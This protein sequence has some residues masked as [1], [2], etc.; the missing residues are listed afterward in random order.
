MTHGLWGYPSIF[1]GQR[2]HWRLLA[3]CPGS[4]YSI[5]GVSLFST[6]KFSSENAQCHLDCSDQKLY[7]DSWHLRICFLKWAI[8]QGQGW[9][10]R[11]GK[12]VFAKLPATFLFARCSMVLEYVPTFNPKMYKNVIMAQFRR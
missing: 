10:G 7:A 2:Q 8:R 6:L 9:I 12:L 5:L 3:F 11:R 1:F 4:R